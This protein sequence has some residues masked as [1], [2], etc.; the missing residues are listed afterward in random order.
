VALI[1]PISHIL[2]NALHIKPATQCVNPWHNLIISPV[3]YSAMV[4]YA[5]TV[6]NV[7]RMTGLV[8]L[9]LIGLSSFAQDHLHRDS[10]E[11]TVVANPDLKDNSLKRTFIGK[12]YRLEWTQPV[13]VPIINLGVL[14][15]KADKEGGGKQTRSLKVEDPS[16]NEYSLRSI[17]KYPEKAIPEELKHTIGEKIVIDGISASYPYGTLSMERFSI[18]AKVPYYKNQLVFLQDDPSLGAFRSKYKNTLVLL[19]AESP[20]GVANMKDKDDDKPKSFDTNEFVYELQQSN[21][22]RVDQYEVLRARLLDN[23]VMDFDR[24]EKQW[25]WVESDA[26]DKKVYVAVPKDHDQ[27]FFTNQG[28]IPKILKGNL[29]ELQGF[30][31]KA[32][33]PVTFNRTAINF[34][35]YFLNG[36][37]EM[38]WRSA[39][40]AFLSA[41]SDSVIDAALKEQPKEI[42]SFAAPRIAETLKEKRKYFLSDMMKY[43]RHLA[44]A[45]SIIGSNDAEH[46]QLLAQENG[47]LLVIISD[48]SGRAVY[49]RVFDPTVTKEIRLY[50][51]EGDD[52]FVLEGNKTP[53]RIRIIGGPGKDEFINNSNDKKIWVYDV[54]VEKNSVTGG[55]IKNRI[56]NNPMNNEY[57]RLGYKFDRSSFGIYSEY[58]FDGGLYFGARWRITKQGFRKEPYAF[59]QDIILAHTLTVNSFLVR[60]N[61]DFIQAIGKTD[62]LVRGEYFRP[63]ARTNFFG[64][65]NETVFDQS[66]PGGIQFYRARYDLANL[67]VMA[68][69]PITSWMNILYGPSFQYF[70]FPREENEN[71]FITTLDHTLTDESRLHE[72]NFYRGGIFQWNVDTRNNEMIPSRGIK[73]NTTVRSLVPFQGNAS[74]LT[75]VNGDLSLYTDFISK[76]RFVFATR[77][78]AGYNFGDYQL[79]QAQYLGFRE[80]LRGFRIHRFAGRS[81]AFNN[82][83]IRWKLADLKTFLCPAQFGIVAFNDVGRVWTVNE[84]SST[85]HDGYGGGLWVAPFNKLVITGTLSYSNE[86]KN[87]ALLTFGFQ[88]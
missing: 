50:G 36:L 35:N 33:N 25:K 73:F 31:A 65:G 58:P 60:Y 21:K 15:W 51:L 13:R 69:T 67:S 38:Q 10:S 79:P 63:T 29:P 88:F 39:I 68:R 43:Y 14:G 82:A 86:E 59:Q 56:S 72:F 81:M 17:R 70:Q 77:F 6:T 7:R 37:N 52:Q 18:A 44:K 55:S 3:N 26:G 83:E 11:V 49:E 40:D 23:F 41:M 2:G 22:K 5:H 19:E 87:F 54:S 57:E 4:L 16:G 20:T 62:I 80:N 34:D 74:A 75:Q 28:I 61:A 53:I 30:R 24:H 48:S 64:L 46:F 1:I 47:R 8:L 9:H 66:K 76:K 84:T 45:V 85:W 12:N 32:K 71:K 78:G 27:V 42:R